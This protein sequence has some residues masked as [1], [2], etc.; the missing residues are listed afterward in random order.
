MPAL[1][2][3]MNQPA[4]LAILALLVVI[5]LAISSQSE[6]V[7][8]IIAVV[9]DEVITLSMV[10]DATDA[11]WTERQYMPQS[12]QEALQKLIDHKLMLQE[13]RKRG[14][15]VSAESLSN[16]V[17]GIVSRFVSSEDFSQALQQRGITQEDLEENLV[18]QIMIQEM[19]D[20]KFRQFLE[21]S[22]QQAVVFFENNKAKYVIPEKVHLY[23][24]FFPFTP[25]ADEAE[26]DKVRVEAET[27]LE[28]LRDGASFLK[29]NTGEEMTDYVTLDR[30]RPFVASAISRL[31][32]G[33]ISDLVETPAAY[34]IIKLNDRR[35]TRQAT[36]EDVE[37][38][39]K[40]SLLQQRTDDELKKWLSSQRNL[41]DIRTR[42]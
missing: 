5:G 33:E 9:N 21:V 36:Y 32:P 13:A 31:K 12:R 11:I 7:D 14:I 16:A 4:I 37:E 23:Q 24:I 28:E 20:R 6:I 18:Q 35:P 30:L 26:R 25:D 41:A 3:T 2:E 1:P 15:I 10:E 29:Y 22:D 40:E 34:F 38:E 8:S 39:I 19:I 27:A 17:A 42:K